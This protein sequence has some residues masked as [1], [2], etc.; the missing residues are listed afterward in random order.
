MYVGTFLNLLTN[1]ENTSTNS[2]SDQTSTT[3]VTISTAGTSGAIQPNKHLLP[4][5]GESLPD[6]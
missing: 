1:Q 6:K 2:R 5:I 3:E 4:A